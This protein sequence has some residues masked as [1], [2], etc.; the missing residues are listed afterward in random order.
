MYFMVTKI[1][2]CL[3]LSLSFSLCPGEFERKILLSVRAPRI[4]IRRHFR[5]LYRWNRQPIYR[6]INIHRVVSVARVN[7]NRKNEGKTHTVYTRDNKKTLTTRPRGRNR[8]CRLRSF[9]VTRL[10]HH[11]CSGKR[12]YRSSTCTRHIMKH[13]ILHCRRHSIEWGSTV[14]IGACIIFSR[15]CI[16]SV[17]LHRSQRKYVFHTYGSE[18]IYIVKL[19]RRWFSLIPRVYTV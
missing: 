2:R 4:H 17:G 19:I 1:P 3:F 6:L 13:C 12:S 9:I 11:A 8:A 5:L 10:L 15:S 7:G 18:V 16:H 14:K